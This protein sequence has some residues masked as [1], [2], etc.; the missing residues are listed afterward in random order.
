MEE[1][2]EELSLGKNPV[3][4]EDRA[5]ELVQ[6]FLEEIPS[7]RELLVSLIER[8][9]LTEDKDPHQV[10]LFSTGKQSINGVVPMPFAVLTALFCD[11]IVYINFSGMYR[12][13]TNVNDV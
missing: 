12:A 7:N 2:R 10:S 9:E 1:K 6:R 4:K 13:E 8:V 5:K 3:K 11:R